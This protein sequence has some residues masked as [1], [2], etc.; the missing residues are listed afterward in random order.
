MFFQQLWVQNIMA[1]IFAIILGCLLYYEINSKD[2][3]I[4]RIV[5]KERP[6]PEMFEKK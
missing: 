3:L 1:L 5:P 6:A 2:E 4:I